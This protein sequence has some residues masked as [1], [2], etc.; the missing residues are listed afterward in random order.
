MQTFSTRTDERTKMKKRN[1]SLTKKRNVD[2]P[3]PDPGGLKEL[4]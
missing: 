4:K 1:V 2:I 3:N